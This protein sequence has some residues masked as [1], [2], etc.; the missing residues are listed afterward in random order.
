MGDTR[1]H[2]GRAAGQGLVALNLLPHDWRVVDKDCDYGIR[3]T[4]QLLFEFVGGEAG[5]ELRDQFRGDKC[6]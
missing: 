5:A 3:E 6:A 4:R 2:R 1:T